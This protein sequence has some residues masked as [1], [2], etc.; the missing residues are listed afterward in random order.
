MMLK[1]FS[2]WSKHTTHWEKQKRYNQRPLASAYKKKS[3]FR[4]RVFSNQ[5]AHTCNYFPIE[6]LTCTEQHLKRIIDH[7]RPTFVF[8]GNE[9]KLL[10]FFIYAFLYVSLYAVCLIWFNPTNVRNVLALMQLHI[11]INT[12]D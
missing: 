1:R 12:K 4:I 7:T 6:N 8:I 2:K 10:S 9:G 5:F 11:N 3:R